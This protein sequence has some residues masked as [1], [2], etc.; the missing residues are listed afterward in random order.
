MRHYVNDRAWIE[1][2]EA[3]V[4]GFIAIFPHLVVDAG[5]D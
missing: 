5:Q 4:D 3:D 2:R 1:N